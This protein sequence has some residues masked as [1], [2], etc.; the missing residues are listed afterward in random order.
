MQDCFIYYVKNIQLN[1]FVLFDSLKSAK[2]IWYSLKFTE[3]QFKII[4]TKLLHQIQAIQ[5][6]H[7]NTATLR[8]SA[9]LVHAQRRT[10]AMASNAIRREKLYNS[11][12]VVH[13]KL[14]V[15]SERINWP[16]QTLKNYLVTREM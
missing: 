12:I 6:I 8:A 11:A 2:Y 4:E 10:I 3:Q 16:F 7:E 5:A 1:L 9:I 15:K 14:V 13:I